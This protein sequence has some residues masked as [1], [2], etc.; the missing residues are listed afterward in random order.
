MTVSKLLENFIA[1]LIDGTFS[2]GSDERDL[3][4][5]W[6]NRCWFGMF[7]EKTFLNFLLEDLFVDLFDFLE[8]PEKID[9]TEERIVELEEELKTGNMKS[10]DGET[11]TWENLIHSDGTP[12]YSCREEWE[13]AELE[14]I[15]YNQELLN[16]YRNSISDSWKEYTNKNSDVKKFDEEMQIIREWYEDYLSFLGEAEEDTSK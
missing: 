11:Y 14:E 16:E 10:W 13:A 15:N 5:Q 9:Y 4:K 7:P 6:F 2:N 3:A 8:L 12:S 1:D